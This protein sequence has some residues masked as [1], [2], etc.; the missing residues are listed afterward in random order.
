MLPTFLL[1]LAAQAMPSAIP[2]RYRSVTETEYAIELDL[3]PS[4][5]ARIEFRGWEADDP[6]HPKVRAFRGTWSRSAS[7]VV[8]RFPHGRT[9][10]F[11]PVACLMY[12]E[13]GRQGCSPGLRLVRT[14]LS[15]DYGLARF[16]LWRSDALPIGR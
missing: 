5:R 3:Q 1:A 16:G 9:V 7:Q 2:G 10:I 11:A 14:N 8:V 15:R 6:A 4:G 12:A 13:F